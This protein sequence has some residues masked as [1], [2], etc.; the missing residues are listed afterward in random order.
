MAGLTMGGGYGPLSGRFGLALDNLLAAEVVL[1]D[2][3]IVV[4]DDQDEQE[5]LWALRGGGG[6]FGVVTR[7]SCRV[8]RLGSVWSGLLFFPLSETRAVL[9]GCADI[10]AAAPDG[11]T[12][13]VGCIAAANGSLTTFVWPTWSG[14]PSDGERQVAPFLKLGTV[15]AGSLEAK[16]YHASSTSFDPYLVKGLPTFM[17]T[18][19]IPSLGSAS[20]EAFIE[21]METAISPGCAV[22]THEFRG[23]A[24]RVPLEAT[25]F[26]LRRDHVLV[27]ILATSMGDAD[28]HDVQLHRD[29]ARATLRAFDPL[30]LPGGYPNLLAPGDVARAVQA[31]GPNAQRLAGAKRRYDPDNIFSSAIPLPVARRSRR[32]AVGR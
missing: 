16:S 24:S 28:E 22:I 30:A 25:A 18:C 19:W 5:L 12:A 26:G 29:W 15:L 23:A 32:E 20:I 2:G 21:A 1:A 7:M 17:E 14:R 10:A 4:A 3:R 27:E 13:Q 9:Q 8:H 6:N 11:L 31:Y